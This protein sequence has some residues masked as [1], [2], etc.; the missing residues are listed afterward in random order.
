MGISNHFHF[1][2]T[3]ILGVDL[4]PDLDQ[5]KSYRLK[6]QTYKTCKL[7]ELEDRNDLVNKQL[8]MF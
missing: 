3:F 4:K 2:T 7:N 6:L 1:Q 8:E 5:D